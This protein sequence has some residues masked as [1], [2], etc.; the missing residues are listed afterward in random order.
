MPTTPTA[1]RRWM[2]AA[3][4]EHKLA[5]AER[6]ETS[7]TVLYQYAMDPANPNAREFSPTRAR[8]VEQ[9]TLQLAKGDKT[10]PEGIYRTDMNS[11]C[12][13]CDFAQK[14]L[15]SK[16]VAS[17]FKFLPPDDTEGGAL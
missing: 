15:G 2:D 12:R 6:L 1:F 10:A 17:D 3:S 11:E 14:C 7:R 8:L 5:L 4:P 9:F 13:E 16:A